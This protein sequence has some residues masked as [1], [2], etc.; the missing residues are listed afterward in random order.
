MHNMMVAVVFLPFS[1]LSHALLVSFFEYVFFRGALLIEG[2]RNSIT[3]ID[4][5][6]G[7]GCLKSL[8]RRC[9]RYLKHKYIEKIDNL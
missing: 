2:R 8:Q 6:H 5:E 1:Y 7:H 3:G 9:N 4:G